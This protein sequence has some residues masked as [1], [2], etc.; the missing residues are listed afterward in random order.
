M[1]VVSIGRAVSLRDCTGIGLMV[2]ELPAVSQRFAVDFKQGA[3]LHLGFEDSQSRFARQT[4]YSGS[5]SRPASASPENQIPRAW[6]VRLSCKSVVL[7]FVA[8][9]YRL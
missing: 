6:N 8:E 7:H 4:N 5:T 1:L 9:S 2:D 3:V